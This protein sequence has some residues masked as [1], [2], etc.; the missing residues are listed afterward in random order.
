MSSCVDGRLPL[1][2]GDRSDPPEDV[3]DDDEG[4]KPEV[5]VVRSTPPPPGTPLAPLIEKDLTLPLADT[6]DAEVVSILGAVEG[7]ITPLRPP[8]VLE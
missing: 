8:K 7:G 6:A 3:V 1:G 5:A 4:D 2:W